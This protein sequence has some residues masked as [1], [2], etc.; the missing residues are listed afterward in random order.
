APGVV[1]Q[2]QAQYIRFARLDSFQRINKLIRKYLDID[3]AAFAASIHRFLQPASLSPREKEGVAT[4]L[5]KTLDTLQK[6][7]EEISRKY[8]S[9]S[10]YEMLGKKKAPNFHFNRGEIYRIFEWYQDKMETGQLWD[11]LDMIPQS[12]PDKY[13]YDILVC[14]EV[15]DLSDTQLDLLFHF[16]KNPRNM[17]LAGDTR[18]T[19]NPSGFRWE[20]VRSHFYE[21]GVEIPQL[22]TLSLNFR[23][24]GSIIELS[25]ILLELQEKITGRTG[26]GP[27][28]EWRYK[29]RPVTVVSG[30]DTPEML[31]ILKQTGAGRTVLVRSETEKEE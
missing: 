15:Q 11:E 9:F 2:L 29:G 8:L 6:H 26:K 23:S 21:R 14:D 28:E 17:F 18:Q 13:T 12:I 5:T 19:I 1:N 20:E 3:I 25:N 24:S 7:P 10:E 16:V 31:D 27:R 30:I 4:I 22:K